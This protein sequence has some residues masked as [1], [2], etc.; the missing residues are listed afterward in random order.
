MMLA[1]EMSVDELS[2]ELSWNPTPDDQDRIILPD[3][4]LLER[5]GTTPQFH[6]RPHNRSTHEWQESFWQQQTIFKNS[7]AAKLREAGMSADAAKLE[8]CHSEFTYAICSDCGQVR[9]FP[10]RCDQ[11]FCPECQPGLSSDRKYQVEW[12]T[13]TI[14][15]PKHVVLTVRNLADLTPGHIDE[16]R[17]YF[18]ALRR[19]AFATK[20]TF[21]RHDLTKGTWHQVKALEPRTKKN[22]F[23]KC[24]PWTGGFYSIECT[25]QGDGWHLHIH[26]LIEAPYIN[27]CILSHLWHKITRRQS[28]IVRVKDCR[29]KSYLAEVTKY[30]VK[31]SDLAKWAPSQV[32]TYIE[33]FRHKR[34]FGVFGKLYAA[35]TEFADVVAQLRTRRP[36]CP[37]GSC[38]VTYYTETEWLMRDLSPSIPSLPR[39]PPPT[40]QQVTLIP[41]RPRWPD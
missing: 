22:E 16:L 31:G 37:C 30:A 1:S 2:Q 15:Q 6:A 39:P 8:D 33:A 18:T 7:L 14:S 17:R 24:K 25:N 41:D 28:H 32:K 23:F 10:N 34:T 12:W 3:S 13:R 29:D 21:W 40:H 4:I 5:R 27:G 26:A 20:Q 11:F 36:R 9:K 38:S 35:R 19:S